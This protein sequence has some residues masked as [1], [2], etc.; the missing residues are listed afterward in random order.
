MYSWW[1]HKRAFLLTLAIILSL[2]SFF[3]FYFA[4]WN[5]KSEST[6]I[7]NG[8]KTIL[9]WNSFYGDPNFGIG[10]GRFARNCPIYNNCY[11]T[12]N[13]SFLSIDDFDAVIFHGINQEIDIKDLPEKRSQKQRYVFVTV[14]SPANRNV[15]RKFDG[16]F[17]MTM[18]HHLDSDVVWNYA[19]Y[20]LKNNDSVIKGPL[21]GPNKWLEEEKDSEKN[22]LMTENDKEEEKQL[23]AIVDGKKKIVA[24][25]RS[26][27]WTRS[28]REN[29]VE[30]L[31]R[32][33]KVN[34]F[35]L[36]NSIEHCPE[37]EDCFKTVL[38]PNYFFH[39][40]FENSLCDDYVTEKLF[41]TFK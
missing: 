2:A 17:N 1:F 25:Y 36:C 12:S 35:G 28:H 14:E 39:L 21:I 24:W 7:D 8:N 29:Y 34:K 41:R 38:E 3:G 9:F 20:V 13:R 23:G 6:T 4:F 16:F 15:A 18:T 37:N 27:C 5:K 26:N 33:V 22:I 40:V 31:S 19:D 30:E 10:H 32:Y 11:A